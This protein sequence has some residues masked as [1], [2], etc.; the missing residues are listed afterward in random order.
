MN[1]HEF[2]HAALDKNFL[3]FVIDITALELPTLALINYIS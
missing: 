3:T 2:A 1:K